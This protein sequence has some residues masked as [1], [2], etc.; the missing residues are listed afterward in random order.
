MDGA[1]FEMG[2]EEGEPREEKG[3]SNKSEESID[4]SDTKWHFK[5]SSKPSRFDLRHLLENQNNQWFIDGG[6]HKF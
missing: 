2:K 4:K 5:M 3:R 1:N 6:F